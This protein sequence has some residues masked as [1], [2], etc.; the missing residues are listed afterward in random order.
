MKST[1]CRLAVAGAAY[2]LFS[3]CAIAQTTTFEN[4]FGGWE[5][6][7]DTALVT[8]GSNRLAALTTAYSSAQDDFD[9]PAGALNLS[10]RDPAAA[11]YD[12]ETFVGVA[13]GAL[14]RDS[15]AQ[16]TE[17]SAMRRSF[18]VMAGDRLSFDWQLATRDTDLALDYAFVVIDGQRW[19]LAT[20]ASATAP[21]S[22]HYLQQTGTSH[23][24]YTFQ[25]SGEIVVAFGVV[26]VGDY[27][28]TSAVY[29]DNV[30][31]SAVPEPSSYLLMLGGIGAI[32][33]LSMRKRS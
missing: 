17:G 11:G 6:L 8:S 26:D 3:T 27:S 25:R 33:G 16:A 19:D 24:Q 7:G 5:V 4:G 15:V 21:G 23:A 13:P 1:T 32:A 30:S 22:S 18:T 10:G 2:A 31:V 9:L 12:L 28:A 29:L 20:A 14:D